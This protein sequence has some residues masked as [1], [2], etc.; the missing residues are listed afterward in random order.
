MAC[1]CE[2]GNFLQMVYSKKYILLYYLYIFSDILYSLWLFYSGNDQPV[3]YPIDFQRQLHLWGIHG[4]KISCGS[5]CTNGYFAGRGLVVH[6]QM[7]QK[8]RMKDNFS[9]NSSNY[10]RYRPTYPKELVHYLVSLV[11]SREI[12]WDCGTGNGQFAKAVAP[13]FKRVEATDISQQQM[14]EA[15]LAK[16]IIY[17]CTPAEKT[18]F[19]THYFDLVTV[20][21]AVHWF[22]FEGFYEEVKRVLKPG[23]MICITGYGLLRTDNATNSIIDHFYKNV[24][25]P[26]WDPERKYLEASY[27]TIPF[28]FEEIEAPDFVMKYTWTIEHLLGYLRTWS[29]VNHFE[30]KLHFDPVEEIAARLKESF[31]AV[32]EVAFP[33]FLRIGR[34]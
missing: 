26:Y 16:N 28:P 8:I 31:G 33:I 3:Q 5:C 29:A 19:P 18:D 11:N 7:A 24:V 32:R 12:A 10:S 27:E 20:A 23:G 9:H 14:G 30:K 21:Q 15:K 22:D 25:G 2:R 13:F 17:T 4:H 6:T 34:N 1:F